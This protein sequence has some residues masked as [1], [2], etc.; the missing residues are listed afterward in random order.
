MN[1]I[2][3]AIKIISVFHYKTSFF[4]GEPLSEK[5]DLV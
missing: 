2:Y 5:S 4:A 1:V 3:T